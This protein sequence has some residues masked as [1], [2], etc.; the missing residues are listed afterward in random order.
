MDRLIFIRVRRHLYIVTAQ[1]STWLCLTPGYSLCIR[2]EGFRQAQVQ[3]RLK[4]IGVCWDLA[5]NK[6]AKHDQQKSKKIK[7]EYLGKNILVDDLF[8]TLSHNMVK[9]TSETSLMI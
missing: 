6:I 8:I 2:G 9:L 4:F 3:T 7:Q 5:E 1:D